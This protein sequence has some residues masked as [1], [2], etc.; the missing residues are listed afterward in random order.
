MKQLWFGIGLLV[1]LLAGSIFLG[2]VLEDAHMPAAADLDRAAHCAA[3]DDWDLAAAL[4][5]RAEKSWKARRNIT[6]A[7][8]HHDPLDQIELLFARLEVYRTSEN[9]AAFRAVC[10][11]LSGRIRSLSQAHRFTWWNLL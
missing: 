9:T 4:V 7:L 6:A 5:N 11:E 1:F 8:I 10:A 2:N 3:K